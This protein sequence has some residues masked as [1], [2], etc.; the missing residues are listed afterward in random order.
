MF[1]KRLQPLRYAFS[2]GEAFF[3]IHPIGKFDSN[4][5]LLHHVSPSSHHVST[6]QFFASVVFQLPKISSNKPNKA[7]EETEAHHNSPQTP[8]V[9]FIHSKVVRP[10][11]LTFLRLQRP[12]FS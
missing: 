8:K 9:R 1:V 4:N 11:L 6:S 5:H 10:R 7:L 2:L 12:W 3:T